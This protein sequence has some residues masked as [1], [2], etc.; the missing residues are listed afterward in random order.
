MMVCFDLGG[1]L[2][3]IRRTWQACASAAGVKT[4]LRDD[5]IYDLS[6]FVLFDAF[7]LGALAPADYLE[8]LSTYL[9]VPTGE[10]KAVHNAILQEPYE[11]TAELVQE[12]K[13]SGHATACLSNTNSLHWEILNS[14][15]YP[16]I[17]GLDFKMVSHTIGLLKPEAAVFRRFDLEAE[18]A[19][20]QVVYFDDHE[21]NVWAA[22]SH[23]WKAVL[24]DHLGDPAAQMREALREIDVLPQ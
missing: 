22:K 9:G 2:A 23:G 8:K 6:D 17:E 21:G 15:V 14:A 19:P 12:I 1:V 5:E 18:V 11:G 13:S 7:Q 3:R 16:S 20:G 24:V 10:A 4:G